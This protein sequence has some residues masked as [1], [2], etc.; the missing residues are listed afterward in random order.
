MNHHRG[1][2]PDA[3]TAG[4][5]AVRARADYGPGQLAAYLLACH[6]PLGVSVD[7][8]RTFGLLPE[9]DR[10][11][12]RPRWSA[13]LAG[14]IR[15]RW[16]QIAAAARC[17]GAAGLKARG[18]T[19][20]MIRDLLGP[21]DLRV[22]NPHHKRMAPMRLWRLQ[23]AEAI[24]ATPEFAWYRDRAARRCAAAAKAAETRKIWR[25]LGGTPASPGPRRARP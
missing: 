11:G 7:R 22:D 13:A 18:W 14:D 17:I 16:P 15:D 19:E 23:R 1:G 20:A 6:G 9:P 4:G 25:A 24:E 12:S 3:G 5:P 2:R 8:A 21:P 10:G